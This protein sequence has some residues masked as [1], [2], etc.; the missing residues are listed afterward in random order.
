MS[1][2]Y[3]TRLLQGQTRLSCLHI[4]SDFLTHEQVSSLWLIL[5]DV[6]DHFRST[7]PVS[8]HRKA[9]R[10]SWIW[11]NPWSPSHLTT[12]RAMLDFEWG[13]HIWYNRPETCFPFTDIYARWKDAGHDA[14]WSRISVITSDKYPWGRLAYSF[15]LVRQ[16]ILGK[17]GGQNS[18]YRTGD[19]ILQEV[20]SRFGIDE[21]DTETGTQHLRNDLLQFCSLECTRKAMP[22]LCEVKGDLFHPLINTID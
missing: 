20:A 21:E 19:D 10:R 3:S 1:C 16:L 7:F 18:Q 5:L 13:S 8:S 22:K 11:R 17:T 4:F 2:N 12:R 6:K 15:I 14:N 9:A